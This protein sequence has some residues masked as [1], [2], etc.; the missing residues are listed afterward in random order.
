MISFLKDVF[1]RVLYY[2]LRISHLQ[3]EK[4]NIIFF[5]TRRG[6]STFFSQLITISDFNLRY[7]DHL[8]SWYQ[9]DFVSRKFFNPEKNNKYILKN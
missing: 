9:T 6:G 2:V 5:S 7:Y 8:F 1:R 4:R 3:G